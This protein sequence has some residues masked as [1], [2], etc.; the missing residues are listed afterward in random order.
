M[1]EITEQ[2]PSPHPASGAIEAELGRY[3]HGRVPRELR[4]RQLLGLA[5]QLFAERGYEAASMDELA[6]RAG[7][8]KPVIYRL[9]DSKQGLF[10]ACTAELGR[11]LTETVV[12]AVAGAETPEQLLRAGSVA[13]FHFV[14]SNGGL[15]SAAYGSADA[16]GGAGG[17]VAG[18][19]GEIR[20]RQNAL[21][22][23]LIL[24]ATEQAEVKLEPRADEAF[25]RGLNGMYEGLAAWAL[26]NPEVAA[27]R[28]AD[29]IVAIVVPGFESLAEPPAGGSEAG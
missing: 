6:E 13:F 3:R 12:A 10:A 9:F 8:S 7:V 29:W 20:A 26:E 19:L 21:V 15:W 1:S 22:R 25:A 18:E 27:E 16:S 5:A 24:A 14:R 17:E 28:L 11:A 4:E 23:T 2:R